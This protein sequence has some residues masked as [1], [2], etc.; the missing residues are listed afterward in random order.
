MLDPAIARLLKDD[1]RY[2]LEAVLGAV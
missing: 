1:R 2:P